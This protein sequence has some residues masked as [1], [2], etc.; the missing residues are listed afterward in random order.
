ML[1]SETNSDNH[2]ERI[3]TMRA[4]FRFLK[5]RTGA[6]VT[7][8]EGQ[9]YVISFKTVACHTYSSSSSIFHGIGPLVDPF[10]SHA[11]R[12]LFNGLPWFLLPVWKYCY[13][14]RRLEKN[15]SGFLPWDL[16]VVKISPEWVTGPE[17]GKS[18]GSIAIFSLWTGMFWDGISSIPGETVIPLWLGRHF[19]VCEN[20][21]YHEK[22]RMTV[23]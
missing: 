20:R 10:R 22:V 4:K 7:A 19:L 6:V 1:L 14:C 2:V 9:Y 12:S 23:G 17:Q 8:L 15:L 18:N 21:V 13:P 3:N 5:Q 11:S 16:P